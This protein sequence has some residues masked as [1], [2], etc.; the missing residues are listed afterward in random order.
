MPD[1]QHSAT[2]FCSFTHKRSGFNFPPNKGK[3]LNYEFAQFNGND[4]YQERRKI[5]SR[6]VVRAETHR[7]N[8]RCYLVTRCVGNSIG[9]EGA[10]S[11][12][13]SLEKNLL[14]EHS[15]HEYS[16]IT[17]P[18]RQTQRHKHFSVLGLLIILYKNV[19]VTNCW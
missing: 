9:A 11:L 6:S 19:K 14:F 7:K 12:A 15:S 4:I 18:V 2:S 3:P 13:S 17:L 16:R 5:V 8:R 10:S 1:T